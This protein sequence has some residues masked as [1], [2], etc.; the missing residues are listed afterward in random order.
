[1]TNL[2]IPADGTIKLNSFHPLCDNELGLRAIQRYNFPPF[3]DGSCRREPDFQNPFPSISALCRGGIFAPHLR[4][5]DIVMYITVGGTFRPFKDGHH[6]VAIL[7]V[8]QVFENH[9]L[10]EIAYAAAGLPI[11]RNCMVDNNPP[12]EFSMTNGNFEKQS[13]LKTFL[14][15]TNEEQKQIGERRL[16]LWN[17]SYFETSNAWPCFI[18]TRPLYLN[19]TAPVHISR[20]DFENIFNKIPNTLT[21]NILNEKEFTQLAQLVDLKITF[22][23]Q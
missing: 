10:G 13:Q 20:N 1:M 11:P 7:Q 21:P 18:K 22:E 6:L 8:E 23:K 15:R 19:I 16:R 4:I 14:A 17:D 2:N 12:L 5:N 9:R 3:I